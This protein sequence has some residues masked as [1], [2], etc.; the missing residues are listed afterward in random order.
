M[1]KAFGLTIDER[2]LKYHLGDSHPM[3][4]N[5]IFP[6]YHLLKENFLDLDPTS[7]SLVTPTMIEPKLLAKAHDPEYIAKINEFSLEGN[8]SAIEYGLGTSD[9]PVFKDMAET[10][11][12]VVSSTVTNVEK[13]F[14]DEIQ[15][16]FQLLGGLHH[17][18]RSKASGFCYYND[19]NVAIHKLKQLKD[20]IKILYFDSDLHFGD[21]VYYDFEND[22]NV[23]KISFH[24]S[25]HFLFPGTGFSE[26]VGVNEG[27]GMGVNQPFFPYTWDEPYMKRFDSIIPPLFESYNPDFV[28]W[29]AGVDGHALDPLG[30]LQLTT[31]TYHHMAKS[32]RELAD[33]N[34]NTPRMLSLGGGGYNSDSVARSWASIVSG[35]SKVKLPSKASS[36]W[37]NICKAQG[38]SVN[39]E[40]HDP[41]TTSKSFEDITDIEKGNNLYFEQ[42]DS[43]VSK[44]HSI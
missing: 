28:I 44:Y 27:E 14:N 20:D 12:I 31:N 16:S 10:A 15:Y 3:N 22:P 18:R 34:M 43:I 33:K 40:L 2:L 5:R 9:C 32:L 30:H 26:E 38:I 11:E 7:F 39:P 8:G 25:G 23:L 21:G 41:M 24:E 35:L 42:F 1:S 37:V 19:I 6:A 36:E 13:I 17:A 4:S 29:Q